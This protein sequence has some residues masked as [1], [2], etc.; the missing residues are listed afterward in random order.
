M[1][2]VFFAAA[3]V[4]T[5]G[6]AGWATVGNSARAASVEVSFSLKERQVIASFF[7]G[8]GG[9]AEHAGKGKGK[10]NKGVGNQ[11]LPPGLA[12]RGGSLPP[13]IAKRQLPGNLVTQLP[14]PPSGYERVIVDNDVLLVEVATQIVHDVL[15]DVIR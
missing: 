11:G 8:S 9:G 12:K 1:R 15:T 4:V 2:K 7:A 13:G 6:I 5:V 14:P 10:K 3:M